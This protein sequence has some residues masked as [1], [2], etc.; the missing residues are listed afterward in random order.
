MASRLPVTEIPEYQRL[1]RLRRQWGFGLSSVM[2][3]AYLAFILL[4]AFKPTLLGMPIAAGSV[5][6]LGIP[7]GLGLIVLAVALTGIYVYLSNTI[8]DPLTEALLKK[9]A[10]K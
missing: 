7:M 3:A 9:A 4:I 8:F 6:S 2:L 10:K 5:I 1:V